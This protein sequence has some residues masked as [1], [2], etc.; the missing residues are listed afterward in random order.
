MAKNLIHRWFG[1]PSS[2]SPT[3]RWPPTR[4]ADGHRRL[5]FESLETRRML[6]TTP[7]TDLTVSTSTGEKPQSKAWEYQ[8]AWYSV[9]PNHTGTW[10]WRLDGA[11]WTPQLKLSTNTSSQADVLAQGDLTYILLFEGT[12]SQFATVQFNNGLHT[13]QMWSQQPQLTSVSLSSGV[14]TAT[15]ALDSAGRV[16]IASDA[17]T[18]IEVR[19]SDGNHSQWSA[20]ITLATGITTDDI[21]SIVALPN[22]E[23]G[24][25]W[26][27]QNAQR[28]G[29]RLHVDG[30]SPTLWSNDEVPASQS[31]LKKGAGFADDHMHLAVATNGTLYVA[32][33]T[34]Y[35]SAGFATIIL[36]VRRPNGVWDNAYTVDTGGTRPVVVLNETAN[37]LVVAYT[38]QDGGGNILYR[39]SPM[40]VISLSPVKVL[41]SGTINNVT[42]TKQEF[43][44]DV[45]F[46]AE[47][48]GKAKG[49]DFRL[50]G[51]TPPQG[52]VNQA[53]L[54]N[55]GADQS[56]TFGSSLQLA[57]V[58]T[59]DNL[60]NPP[61]TV[62]IT[63]TK[64]SGSGN[65][66]FTNVASA[67]SG[68]SF[69][70]PGQYVLRLTAND[71][72]SASN[73][74]TVIVVDPNAPVT[75]SFQDGQSPTLSY[76]GTRDTKLDSGS[77]KSNFGTAT[78]LVT[79]GSPDVSDLLYWDISSIPAGSVIDSAAIQLNA[80]TT[81]KQA[82]P[83]YVMNRAWDELSATWN[84]AATGSPWAT[85]ALPGPPTMARRRLV[86]SRCRKPVR[87]KSS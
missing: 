21:S 54:V 12:A 19:Y 6:S 23:I 81:G 36:L 87:S 20:P 74:V 55:A 11:A 13:Y 60:P 84:Q 79:D 16:W 80:T 25:F 18:S 33:K 76:Q 72:A 43:T 50:D 40:D 38:S 7:L 3:Y 10:L 59:D 8:G 27:N 52:P 83:L 78:T 47:G 69:S 41:I 17:K 32:A 44:D 68:A 71:G 67:T 75:A 45:V 58:V 35:D 66:S 29:F 57:G 14:E 49:V 51:F 1:A 22:H 28:F 42:T 31:A 30:A 48:G 4:R 37:E 39:V 62:S 26:S 53:P 77:K 24:V 46:L 70:S 5:T 64:I 34:G 73:D 85:P 2:N 65:V 61:G 82:Y 15:L 9:L 56:I 86:N 63:W